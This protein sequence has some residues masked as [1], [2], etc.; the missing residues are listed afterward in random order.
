[1]LFCGASERGARSFSDVED[2]ETFGVVAT[3]TSSD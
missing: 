1:M 2:T 3:V